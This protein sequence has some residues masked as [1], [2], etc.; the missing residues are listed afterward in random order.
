MTD[1]ALD[2]LEILFIIIIPSIIS[3]VPALISAIAAWKTE[4]KKKAETLT[5]EGSAAEKV[6]M[7]YDR[8]VEDLQIRIDKMEARYQ[9]DSE[10]FQERLKAAE[11]RIDRQGKRI[12]HLEQGVDQ[13]ITQVKSLGAEPVFTIPPNEL[14]NDKDL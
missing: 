14:E 9:K 6:A 13:L 2:L 5:E 11:Q 7:A 3:G 10:Q 1:Y 4:R 12:R 8:L